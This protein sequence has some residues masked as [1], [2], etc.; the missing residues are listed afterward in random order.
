MSTELTK[1]FA[2]YDEIVGRGKETF[3]EVGN[4]LIAI[5]DQHLYAELYASFDDYT[6]L[7]HGFTKRRANQLMSAARAVEEMR[8]HAVPGEDLPT[9]ESQIRTLGSVADTPEERAGVWGAAVEAA[10]R[11]DD[12]T[13]QVSSSLIKRVAAQAGTTKAHT[14]PESAAIDSLLSQIRKAF[15]KI[16]VLAEEL[17]EAMRAKSKMSGG[18][19]SRLVGYLSKVDNMMDAYKLDTHVADLMRIATGWESTKAEVDAKVTP[20]KTV[21]TLK[22]E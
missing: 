12:G 3:I 7:H 13:P 21:E 9:N 15:T 20:F 8:E 10:D 18:F 2:Y 16:P 19:N 17:R 1:G 4:A 6:E 14:P 22:R 11:L 5:R